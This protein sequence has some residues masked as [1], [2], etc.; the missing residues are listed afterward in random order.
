DRR[1]SPLARGTVRLAAA[2]PGRVGRRGQAL[3]RR[4]RRGRL[5]RAG[6]PRR[7]RVAEQQERN[8]TTDPGRG[9]LLAGGSEGEARRGPAT[10]R[11]AGRAFTLPPAGRG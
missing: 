7:V 4:T 11:R 2:G 6:R 9:R 8:G 3:P 5:A 1:A 10:P